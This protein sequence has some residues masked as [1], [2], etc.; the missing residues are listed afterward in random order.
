M[1]GRL[2]RSHHEL[3]VVGDLLLLAL[4]FLEVGNLILDLVELNL[5]RLLPVTFFSA[6]ARDIL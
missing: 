6:W 4:L 2:K 3:V 5:E 1:T